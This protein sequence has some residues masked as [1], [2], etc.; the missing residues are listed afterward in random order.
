MPK[1]Y[2]AQTN[3]VGGS[4]NEDLLGRTELGFYA[5]SVREMINAHTIPQGGLIRAPGTERLGQAATNAARL[6]PWVLSTNEA[7]VVEFAGTTSITQIRVI[8]GMTAV[9]TFAVSFNGAP[10]LA[11]YVQRGDALIMFLPGKVVRLFRSPTGNIALQDVGFLVAPND[12]LGDPDDKASASN[13]T[14]TVTGTTLTTDVN[15]F[16]QADVGRQFSM[17]EGLATIAT[18]VS[19]QEVTLT[20]SSPFVPTTATWDSTANPK[21]LDSPIANITLTANKV[22]VGDTQTLT[23]SANAWKSYAQSYAQTDIGRYVQINGGLIEITGVTSA[24][25]ATGVIRRALDNTNEAFAGGWRLRMALIQAST[26]KP[27]VGENINAVTIFESRLVLAGFTS[28]PSRVYCSRTGEINDFSTGVVA[29]DA[30]QFDIDSSRADQIVNLATQR[31]LLVFTLSAEY[32]IT[33]SDNGPIRPLS[34]KIEL[35]TAHGSQQVPTVAIDTDE[36]FV[37]RGGQKIRA[38]GYSND[39]GEAVSPDVTIRR[40]DLFE[41]TTVKRMAYSQSPH[42]IMFALGADGQLRL[43]CIDKPAGVYAWS[44]LSVTGV[45][46]IAVIPEDGA[47]RCYIIIQRGSELLIERF[48]YDHLMWG[49]REI[50][51]VA[52]ELTVPHPNGQELDVIVFNTLYNV[53][54]YEGK[55]TV[56]GGKIAVGTATGLYQVGYNAQCKITLLP[57]E[58][59]I[60][61]SLQGRRSSYNGIRVRCYRTNPALK[62]AGDTLKFSNLESPPKVPNPTG[63]F[64]GDAHGTL[65]GWADNQPVVSLIMD[66]PLEF[67][68]VSVVRA[69][70]VND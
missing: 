7:Y 38:Y 2:A 67:R 64:T 61:G 62:V 35:A 24:T 30:F 25:V 6:I 27:H 18:Y 42:Q 33:G 32:A 59:E 34:T 14:F 10:E 55:A 49:S 52:S 29:D 12:E 19:E 9:V 37:Q 48:R 17:G 58:A 36:L 53:W 15:Y 13:P 21:L 46:D 31:A 23:A 22:A 66:A 41:G 56:S 47:D 68:L 63:L 11:R 60:D 44:D 54:T 45:V 20:I 1:F 43:L 26:G 8:S 69:T 39:A 28:F 65:R 16:R 50:T 5:N 57:I 3:F 70:T 40:S 51:A 4:I